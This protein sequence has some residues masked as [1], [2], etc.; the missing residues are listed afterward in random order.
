VKLPKH[1]NISYKYSTF[2]LF[3]AFPLLLTSCNIA[4]VPLLGKI[5]GK[6]TS[7]T[8]QLSLV[9]WGLWN[10]ESVY[11]PAFSAYKSKNPNVSITYQD[12]SII[13]SVDYKERVFTR[14]FEGASKPD[15]VLVHV[16][17]LSRLEAADALVP[18]PADLLSAQELNDNYY[19][20]V[21]ETA[22]SGGKVYSLP[23][24]YD[25][26]VLVYNKKHFDEAGI[27]APPVDWEEFRR[28]ALQLTLRGPDGVKLRSGAA[29]GSADNIDHFS[30]T[31]GLMWAQAGVKYPD[32]L[33][34]TQASDAL[35]FY[36]NFVKEDTV[37]SNNDTDAM[38]AFASGDASMVIVPSWRLHELLQ[39]MEDAS[40]VGVAAVPQAIPDS[41]ATWA[42]YWTWVVPKTSPNPEASWQLIKYLSSEDAQMII[43]SEEQKVRP[44]GTPYASIRLGSNL[45]TNNYLKPVVESAPYAKT[46]EIAGRAGNRKQVDALKKAVNAVL[47]GSSAQDALAVAK[48]EITN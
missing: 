13:P 46:S 48:S 44:F 36:T 34:S 15:V 45:L 41:P 9:V 14:A 35:T 12:Q 7:T 40:D 47:T 20:V 18:M 11:S 24:F 31:L 22:V 5:F 10:T 26:L 42:S 27:T 16:S 33:D 1:R 17:W 23:S 38:L 4:N 21:K 2:A 43:F 19:P 3:F 29:I 28:I 6:K 32:E 8:E 39:V 25:G 37:W 30:D